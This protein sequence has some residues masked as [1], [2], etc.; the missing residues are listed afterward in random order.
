M[1]SPSVTYSFSNSTTAD[2]TQVN[3]NFQD[4]ISGLSDGT[5]DLSISA[6]TVAGNASF[7]GNVTLGNAT[8]D[9]VT[10]TGSLASTINIKT[11][12]TYNIGSGTLGLAGIYFGQSGGANTA[13]VVAS[14]VASDLTITLPAR[15]GTLAIN[16]GTTTND[17]ASAGDKGEVIT[18]TV[19]AAS[20]VGLTSTTVA[21]VT[22]I[23]LT[24]GDWDVF[25]MIGFIRG[26]GTCTGYI[27]GITTS[28]AGVPD[29]SS[30]AEQTGI[31]MT[32]NIREA[33]PVTRVSIASTTTYYL[34]A[35]AFFSGAY[36]GFGR[37]TA[38]RIR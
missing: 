13:R 1:A 18:S 9:D 10:V 19:A 30:A 29:E 34:V 5:K 8:G 28:S 17:S 22:S 31:S 7:S 4:L 21:N 6:L 26:S 3:Q 35:Q 23:S 38:R 25:G 32:G 2:A 36:S 12:N 27:G 16:A 37:V 33:V 15:T 11:T 14:V 20:P 24:A